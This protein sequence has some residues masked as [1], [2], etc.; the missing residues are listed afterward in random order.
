MLNWL[1]DLTRISQ[2]IGDLLSSFAFYL[3]W[4]VTI[5]AKSSWVFSTS[6]AENN[7]RL[8]V[9]QQQQFMR[10]QFRPLE[11][12]LGHLDGKAS[13]DTTHTC[14]E[15]QGGSENALQLRSQP[16]FSTENGDPLKD[17]ISPS[18]PNYYIPLL[19]TNPQ[20]LIWSHGSQ[21]F[22]RN[23]WADGPATT[24]DRESL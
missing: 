24:Q 4:W 12:R 11:Q 16:T 9:W 13:C 7:C 20:A 18:D 14:S 15:T 22:C 8:D 2:R 23:V 5:A 17:V 1:R 10:L 19:C 6:S 21:I 3:P